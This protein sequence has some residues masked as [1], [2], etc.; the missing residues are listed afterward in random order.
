MR[1]PRRKTVLSFDL[2]FFLIIGFLLMCVLI[3]IQMKWYGEKVWK[4]IFVSLS[5]V[6]TGL[7]SCKVWFFLEN[8]YW[9]ARS[10][11]GAIFFAPLT[12]FFMAKAVKMPYLHSLD[13]CATAGCMILAVLKVD[14]MIGGCCRGI[15]LYVLPN[16]NSAR[17]PSQGAEFILAL[18]LSLFLFRQSKN[19]E[20]R[21][22]I[23][24]MALVFYGI[25]RFVLNLLRDDW[26]RTKELG[27]LLPLGCIWSC[28]A[29]IIGAVW[30]FF[31]NR[32]TTHK[33]YELV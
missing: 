8:G 6:I 1:A 16:G 18:L 23:Y 10:F 32:K 4:S 17:F 13:Y 29:A 31:S 2:T 19:S 22:K 7:I 15:T 5:V 26:E 21:G 33:K 3:S 24:P 12:F 25:Q 20:N 27:L 9:G 30:L 28:L 14:C 11:Y